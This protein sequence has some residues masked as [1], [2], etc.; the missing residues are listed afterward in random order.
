MT[1]DEAFQRGNNLLATAIVAL[2]GFAFL[3]E[4]FF[5]DE[6]LH[7]LD[8]ALLFVL[9]I[10]AIVWYLTGRHRFTH[11]LLP[12][13]LVVAALAVK[14]VGFLLELGDVQDIGDDYGALILFLLASVTVIWLYFRGATAEKANG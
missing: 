5:E 13:L 7:K 3:P 11:S 12:V 8:E 6:T 4:F 1:V 10:I 14:L 9:G 2:S